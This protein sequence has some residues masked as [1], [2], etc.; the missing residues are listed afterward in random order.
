MKKNIFEFNENN[1]CINPHKIRR[2]VQKPFCFFEIRTAK[3]KGKWLA[4]YCVNVLGVGEAMPV[5]KVF[6]PSFKDERLAISYSC[7]EIDK[8]LSKNRFGSSP[9]HAGEKVK[10][11]N[12]Q[13][14][15][16]LG[17]VKRTLNK[18]KYLFLCDN[19]QCRRA[20]DC[21]LYVPYE[22]T[23]ELCGGDG[24][25]CKYYKQNLF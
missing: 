25:Q 9:F 14:L 2:E 11:Y 5:S 4:G 12:D 8:F 19:I 24:S 10:L 3:V 17:D 15:L 20:Q 13:I 16:E 1:V 23:E 6:S 7:K 22:S 18:Q 21:E